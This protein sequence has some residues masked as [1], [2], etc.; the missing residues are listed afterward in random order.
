MASA[1][2][3]GVSQTESRDWYGDGSTPMQQSSAQRLAQV[4]DESFPDWADPE[5]SEEWISQ[6][7]SPIMSPKKAS[8]SVSSRP[9]TASSGAVEG[10]TRILTEKDPSNE[11]NKAA[12][13]E[14]K[15]M[16]NPKDF[17]SPMTLERMFEPNLG[18][19]YVYNSITF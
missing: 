4:Q 3:A 19:L 1:I 2:A 17:F 16:S 18:D 9:T 14:W 13:P 7:N 15:K 10:T 11:Q 8:D 5:L 12:T 6:P